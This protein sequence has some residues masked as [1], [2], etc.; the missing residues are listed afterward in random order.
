MKAIDIAAPSD[1]STIDQRINDL[2]ECSNEFSQLVAQLSHRLAP[3]LRPEMKTVGEPAADGAAKAVESS[4]VANQLS[5]LASCLRNDAN[6]L[7][8][9]INRL[10]V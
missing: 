2:N 7:R 6:Y 10:E 1:L 4:P 8:S 9:L 3:V 5:G